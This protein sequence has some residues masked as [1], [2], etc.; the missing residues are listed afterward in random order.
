MAAP[1]RYPRAIFPRAPLLRFPAFDTSRQWWI[2]YTLCALSFVPALRLYYVGE[3][4]IAFVTSFE[5]WH[6]GEWFT[7]TIYGLNAQHN[8]LFNWLHVPL[9]S[10]VGWEHGLAAARFLMAGSTV[11]TGLVVAWLARELF[12]DRMFAAFSAVV[13][14]T[15]GDLF[16]YRGWLAYADPM[17]MFYVFTG[18]ASLWMACERRSPGL[19]VLG[20]LAITAGFMLK[21]ITAYTFY[22]GAGL[23]LLFRKEYRTFLLSPAS[24]AIHAL[25][26]AWPVIWFV[27]VLGGGGQGTR[28]LGELLDKW[29]GKSLG[30][31]LL[32]L[33]AYLG[34]A[35]F[36]LSPAF[37]L[38]AY[39]LWR[40]RGGGLQPEPG[41][42]HVHTALAI[43]LLNF[44]PY[45]LAPQSQV[46]YLL[47]LYPLFALVIA[48][49]IWRAGA[50]AMKT[51]AAWLTGLLALKL[52]FVLVGFP[53]YQATYRG[54]NYLET[55][56]E[57]HLITRGFP[58]YA[59]DVTA[60]GLSVVAYLDVLLL[61]GGPVIWPPK[62]L[63]SGFVVS[64]RPYPET[65]PIVKSWQLGGNQ[66]HLLCRGA[67]CEAWEQRQGA[68]DSPR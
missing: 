44:M 38:A 55:A 59:T 4:P 9:G 68:G 13:F 10:L 64:D 3:E 49:I 48:R 46:R 22:G 45:W 7:H 66:V 31:Y 14:L 57:I 5:M 21:A 30:G 2:F 27:L 6:R 40:R 17:F 18:I 32:K 28:M 36:N 60:T 58:V 50:S 12:Q 54:A 56:R 43:G 23:I 34:D 53:Y 52:V 29:S 63:E 41:A 61:P 51:T 16:V 47:P 26:F 8:P 24:L 15:L 35:L 1:E 42:A 37:A 33:A 19:L 11:L 39:Y 25:M 20:A 65:G 67:A 62:D